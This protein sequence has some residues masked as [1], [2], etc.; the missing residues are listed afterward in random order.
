MGVEPYMEPSDY[1]SADHFEAK[2]NGY[3]QEV[4]SRG[5]LK[6]NTIILFPEHLGTFLMAANS[7]SRVYSASTTDSA[8]RPLVA[9]NLLTFLKNYFIFDDAD[10]FTA[11]AIRTQSSQ[12]ADIARAVYG[13]L[14]QKY[15]VTIVAGSQALMTPGVYPNSLSYGHGPI[16]NSS[17]VFAPSGKA[18]LDAVRKVHPT[19]SETGFTRA[20]NAEFLFPFDHTTHSFGVL[21]C[22]D[23]WFEDTVDSLA[24]QGARLLLVPAFLDNTAWDEPWQGY[25]NDLPEH[26]EWKKDVG[27]ITEGDAWIKYALPFHAKR[28]DVLWGMTVF[29][30]GT[31]WQHRGDGRA[32]ILEDGFV[33]IGKSDEK[34]AA[35]YNLWLPSKVLVP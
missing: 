31:L 32:I 5:W 21:I 19:L 34:G 33:H 8:L 2:L 18:Q 9:A 15:G 25:L 17:F 35:L 24:S 16:F 14:A 6:D 7:G 13:H 1:S 23:S 11:A 10:N 29:L 12:V 20:S 28:A 30:K 3:L 27:K 22:A 26:S 4:K